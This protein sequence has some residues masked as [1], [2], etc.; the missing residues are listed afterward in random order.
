MKQFAIYTRTSTSMQSTGLEAQKRALEEYCKVRGI[1]DYLIFE[2]AGISGGKSSRPKLDELMAAVRKGEIETV[3]VYSFSRFARNTKFL[4][5]AL[6]EF[7]K[8]K[9]NFISLSENVDLSTPLGKAMFTIISAL[10]TL[11]KDQ[12]S[13]K[14][15]N[16]LVNARAKGKQLGRPKKIDYDLIINLRN[17][18]FTYLQISQTLK[19]SQGTVSTALKK[20]HSEKI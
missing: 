3:L 2:D 12:T 11:E 13:E 9:V 18:G 5:E 20:F 4:L 19:I 15:K 14:V 16:G 1:N 6:D 17:K 10:A 8:L 7:G